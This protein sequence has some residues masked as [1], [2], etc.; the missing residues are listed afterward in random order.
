MQSER[1][2]PGLVLGEAGARLD[3]DRRLAVHAEAAADAHGGLRDRRIDVAALE[4]AAEQD[5]GLR[6]VMQQRR[7]RLDRFDRI[8]DA[9]QRLEIDGDQLDRIL[10]KVTAFRHHPDNGLADIAHLAA[11]QRQDRRRVI[12]AHARGREQRLDR[13]F[14]VVRGQHRKH[15]GGGARGGAIDGADA[16]MRVFAAAEGDM[17]QARHLAVVDVSAEPGQQARVLG[18]LDAGADNFRPRGFRERQ[19]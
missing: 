14:D 12:T 16:R 18:A 15:A 2:A 8:V 3:G 10:G 6:F 17:Q 13:G 9:R 19:S 11:R 7:A 5:V 1:I 4:F